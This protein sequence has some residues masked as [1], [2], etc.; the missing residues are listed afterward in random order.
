M[1]F[2]AVG[3]AGTAAASVLSL[4]KRGRHVQVGLMLAAD[5]AAPMPMA[6]VISYEL[7]L[8]GVHGMAVGHYPALVAEVAPVDSTPVGWSAPASPSTTS[9]PSSRR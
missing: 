6:R 2:D 9:P 5:R 7:S 8:V 3:S 4:R 1:S